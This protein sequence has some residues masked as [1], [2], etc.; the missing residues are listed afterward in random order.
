MM[1]YLVVNRPLQS[2]GS[3]ALM[4]AGLLIYYASNLRSNVPPPNT[5]ST[6]PLKTD[7]LDR[8]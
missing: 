6:V 5:S 7:A 3:L 2:F 8:V 4:T 1:Y